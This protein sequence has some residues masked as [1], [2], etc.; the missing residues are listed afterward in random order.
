MSFSSSRDRKRSCIRADHISTRSA[1]SALRRDPNMVANRSL[2]LMTNILYN[3]I[4]TDMETCYKVFRREVVQQI[5]L[6]A[7]GFE[8]EPEIT[9]KVL[10]RGH[11]IYEVPISYNGR[12]W[13]EGKKIKWYDAP[14]AAWTL[15]R[16][17]FT[18]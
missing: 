10:K 8:F 9:A 14:K 11:R 13:E 15:L 4:L 18:D 1:C 16:Y 12:E 17:R 2:T 3:T 7:R 5:P 6:R